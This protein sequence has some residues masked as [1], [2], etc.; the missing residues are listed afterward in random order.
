MISSTEVE[1]SL[2]LAYFQYLNYCLLEHDNCLHQQE[3]DFAPL[4]PVESSVC[5]RHDAKKASN[6]NPGDC[7]GLKG[8]G[9]EGCTE[10]RPEYWAYTSF[11]CKGKPILSGLVT[12][13][14][15]YSR[16]KA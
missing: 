9:G 7:F 2:F 10:C 4:T 6:G 15:N 13:C 5:R 1:L 12:F 8:V 11:G 16:D 3:P 14:C